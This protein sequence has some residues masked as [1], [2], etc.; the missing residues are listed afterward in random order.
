MY[1]DEINQLLKFT[2]YIINPDTYIKICEQ[3]P[4]INHVKYSPFGDYFE[5]WTNDGYYWKFCVKR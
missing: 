4:Q 1:S 3:S 5:F 2:N